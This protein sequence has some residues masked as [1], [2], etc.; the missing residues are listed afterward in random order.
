MMYK[1]N[2]IMRFLVQKCEIHSLL[3]SCL[4]RKYVFEYYFAGYPENLRYV[5][6]QIYFAPVQDYY[7]M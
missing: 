2:I 3:H 5:K 7:V 4:Q 1:I 6:S